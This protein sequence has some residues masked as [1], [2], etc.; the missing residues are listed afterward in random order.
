MTIDEIIQ[1]HKQG[2]VFFAEINY[3]FR[4][5]CTE[6]VAIPDGIGY[7]DIGWNDSEG[8]SFHPFHAVQG[9]IYDMA[10]GLSIVETFPDGQMRE[11]V[12]KKA[13]PDSDEMREWQ[14]WRQLTDELEKPY[15]PEVAEAEIMKL[16]SS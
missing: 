16:V 12:F 10:D 5:P 2:Q 3:E 9:Q 8:A 7:A 15:R 11:T 1:A 6:L 14:H 13:K 4:R